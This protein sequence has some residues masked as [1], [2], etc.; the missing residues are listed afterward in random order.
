MR[1][2]SEF[3]VYIGFISHVSSHF[4]LYHLPLL[5]SVNNEILGKS[6]QW[7]GYIATDCCY[8]YVDLLKFSL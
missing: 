3:E 6:K 7:H 8:F 4:L 5:R 1:H 2:S